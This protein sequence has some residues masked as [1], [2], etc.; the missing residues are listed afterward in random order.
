MESTFVAVSQTV[1]KH[2]KR[3]T[4]DFLKRLAGD[5]LKIAV[6]SRSRLQDALDLG[7]TFGPQARH[8]PALLVQVVLHI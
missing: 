7:F 3:N 2:R 5:T 6:H 4:L 8:S 1:L